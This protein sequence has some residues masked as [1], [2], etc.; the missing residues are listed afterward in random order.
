LKHAEKKLFYPIIISEVVIMSGEVRE[1]IKE[2]VGKTCERQGQKKTKKK[3]ESGD[4]EHLKPQA[5][6]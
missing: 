1:R 6:I 3:E 2:T 5:M 4:S